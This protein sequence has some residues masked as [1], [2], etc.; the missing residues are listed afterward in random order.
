M[1]LKL[2][3][4]KIIKGSSQ[5]LQDRITVK[6]MEEPPKQSHPLMDEITVR[7]VESPVIVSPPLMDDIS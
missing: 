5:S 4:T 3:I 2:L 6:P 7:P 1:W